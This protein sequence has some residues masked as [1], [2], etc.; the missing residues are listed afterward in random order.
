MAA[1]T[2]GSSALVAVGTSLAAY[3]Q[4]TG[5][6]ATR[7]GTTATYTFTSHG[8]SNGDIAVI[9]GFPIAEFNGVFAVG[10]VV[11]NNFDVTLKQDPGANPS[12][13]TGT[14][15]KGVLG[16]PLDLTTKFDAFVI[17]RIINGAT[18]P[19]PAARMA[20]GLAIANNDY[21]Y[22]WREMILG[23]T[24]NVGETPIALAIPPSA[25]W[26]NVVF[27]GATGQAVDVE[28]VAHYTATVA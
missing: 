4:K 12:G 22:I 13:S 3:T 19:N 24:A 14:L 6:T 27:Y 2:K 11:G 21:D 8:L 9:G 28:A 26:A 20:M 16:T 17:G 15:W 7:S 1:P 5:G 25:L 18:G 23:S 10:N